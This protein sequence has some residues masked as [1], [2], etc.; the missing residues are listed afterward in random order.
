VF[1]GAVPALADVVIIESFPGDLDMWQASKALAA[2]ELAVNPGGVVVL[3]TPCPEGVSSSHPAMLDFGCQSVDLVSEWVQHGEITDLMVAAELAIG[4]RVIR[5]RARGILVSPGIP[6][7]AIRQLGF[8]PA[9][10]PQE[11]L[12]KALHRAGT[13]ARVLVL[14]HG[15]EILPIVVGDGL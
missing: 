1:R 8:E 2:A 5:D 13:E 3:V 7:E 12:E 11:A 14:H 10:A 4:G 9:A 15:G 6:P